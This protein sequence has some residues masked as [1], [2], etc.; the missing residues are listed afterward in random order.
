LLHVFKK[1]FFCLSWILYVKNVFEFFFILKLSNVLTFDSISHFSRS[2]A[3]NARK[4][5]ANKTPERF[6]LFQAKNLLFSMKNGKNRPFLAVFIT[7]SRLFKRKTKKSFWSFIFIVLA[8]ILS[9]RSKKTA[10]AIK[11]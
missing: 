6:F 1:E 7:K 9:P 3:Q 10:Y 5:R 8:R 4:N 2:W 11:S